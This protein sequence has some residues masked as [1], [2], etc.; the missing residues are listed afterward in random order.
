MRR[1]RWCLRQRLIEVHRS[2]VLVVGDCYPGYRA[3]NC[4]RDDAGRKLVL[5]AG[6]HDAS[7]S[8]SDP[9]FDV[10]GDWELYLNNVHL[11]A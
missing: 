1:T 2:A 3:E 4:W 9:G 8:P 10:I 5:E 6:V 11:S 7:G